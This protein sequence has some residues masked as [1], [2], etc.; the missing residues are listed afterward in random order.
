MAHEKEIR[1]QMP[2]QNQQKLNWAKT[3]QPTAKPDCIYG[4]TWNIRGRKIQHF[5]YFEL[6]AGGIF[7]WFLTHDKVGLVEENKVVEW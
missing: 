2:K 4:K 5:F 6:F 3:Q 1:G 7:C